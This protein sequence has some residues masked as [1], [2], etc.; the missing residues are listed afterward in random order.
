MNYIKKISLWGWFVVA[1]AVLA[2]IGMVIYGVTSTTGYVSLLQVG[3]NVA[4]VVC[5]VFAIAIAC[6]LVLFGDKLGKWANLVLYPILV[7][8]II[9]LVYFAF[10]R[11]DYISEVYFIPIAAP[12]AEGQL[13]ST[14]IVGFVFY[15]LSIIS[16]IVAAFGKALHRENN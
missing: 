5:T 4:P 13:V 11:I 2:F 1:S 15:A 16:L 10:G 3:W 12:A 6:A 14:S 7:L 9:S 8:L